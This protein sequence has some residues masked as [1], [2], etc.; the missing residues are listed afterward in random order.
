MIWRSSASTLAT[1]SGILAAMS[2]G[3]RDRPVLVGVDEV[4]G[5]HPRAADLH[6]QAE[7]HRVDVG[8]RHGH[9]GGGELEAERLDLVEVAH[10]AVGDH[11]GAAERLVD[12]GLHLAPLGPLAAGLVEVGGR[13]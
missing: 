8:V 13:R 4:T 10:R 11:A 5:L 12:V 3:T 9:V 7:V 2:A 1:A 6:R